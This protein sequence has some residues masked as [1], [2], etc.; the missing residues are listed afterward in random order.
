MRR[1]LKMWRRIS[2]YRFLRATRSRIS[3]VFSLN[4]F[5]EPAFLQLWHTKYP[6]GNKH[7]MPAQ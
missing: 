7:N 2:T 1:G 5:H 4:E 6:T 3:D